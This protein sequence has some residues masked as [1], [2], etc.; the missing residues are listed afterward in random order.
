[1]LIIKDLTA[2]YGEH[3]VLENLGLSLEERQ[4]H[5]LMGLNGSGKTTLLNSMLG[6]VPKEEGEITF[7]SKPLTAANAGYLETVNYFYPK[8]TGG[9]YLRLFKWKN[10]SFD[11][12]SWNK[13]FELPLSELIETYST[14]MKKKL[15]L[16]GIL[17]LERDLL[18][19][20]EPFNGLDLEA[21]LILN[22]I[23]LLLKQSGKTVLLTSHILSSLF[24]VSDKIHYLNDKKIQRSFNKD[25]FNSIHELVVDK[26][27]KEKVDLAESLIR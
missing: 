22:K 13:I 11:I 24:S 2:A 14:G 17:S 18:L 9:E 25:E 6:I 4:V 7:N 27:L 15:A 21:N 10:N 8:I 23:I 3:I 20:D 5:A 1:M 16:L 26:H 12:D 19:L